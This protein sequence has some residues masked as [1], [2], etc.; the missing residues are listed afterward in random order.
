MLGATGSL[1]MKN[2]TR[3]SD[4]DM[5]V[6]LQSGKIW[7]G[8]TLLTGFLHLIG[9]R[10]YGN[11]IQDRAC[12]NYF[13]TDDNLKIGTQDLFSA[14]E[15]RFIIPFFEK[16]I[17]ELFELKNRW[18]QEYKPNFSLTI[19]PTL[20][21]FPV[22]K[23]QVEIQ[24]FVENILNHFQLE[25]WLASWQ[26]KKIQCNPNTSLEGSFI[27]ADHQSLIFLPRPRGPRVFEK[28]KNRLS[29]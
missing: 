20:W 16:K 4:W 21:T 13:I 18:I 6:V 9:K 15:Y 24:Q 2:G 5:F 25:N 8:R 10:R 1:A 17:Y 22:K 7:T 3:E 23:Q 28:Y 11:K 14:H 12:L 19:V 29:L 27:K 26:K